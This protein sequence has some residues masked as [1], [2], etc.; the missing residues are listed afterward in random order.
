MT[1]EA[2]RSPS[3]HPRWRRSGASALTNADD[4]LEVYRMLEA[5]ELL[6]RAVVVLH[7]KK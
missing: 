5:S 7:V 4:E 1:V 2:G 6:G 3:W